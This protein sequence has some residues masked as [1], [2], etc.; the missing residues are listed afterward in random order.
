MFNIKHSLSVCLN[1]SIED[2]LLLFVILLLV[3]EE[4]VGYLYQR[5]N[6]NHPYFFV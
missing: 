1:V 3:I 6:L 2:L 4:Q 5:T